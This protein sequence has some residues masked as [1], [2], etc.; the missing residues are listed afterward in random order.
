VAGLL[1][2]GSIL[3]KNR[4]G[5]FVNYDPSVA[6]VPVAYDRVLRAT[7]QIDVLS[8][9]TPAQLGVQSVVVDFLVGYGVNDDP[10]ELFF[11]REPINL[12]VS[13]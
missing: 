3:V 1:E 6:L 8:G 9:V 5:D 12:I 4:A 13:P 11:H 7:E 10:E 2:D